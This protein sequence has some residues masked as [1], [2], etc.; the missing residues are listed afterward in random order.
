[1]TDG[2]EIATEARMAIGVI[3]VDDVVSTYI[4]L[5]NQKELLEAQTK[6]KVDAIKVKLMKMEAWFKEQMDLQGVKSFKTNHGTAFLSTT[7]FAQVSDW[8]AVLEFIKQH[9][10]Y[11]MLEKRIAKIA[12]RGYIDKMKAVPP[13]VNYGTKIEVNV[14]K[15]SPGGTADEL[16]K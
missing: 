1:M 4:K 7:D 9:D 8:D 15:P 3:N 5:R 6:D 11:D 14:R 13:G 16:A 10:A 12:V 2:K